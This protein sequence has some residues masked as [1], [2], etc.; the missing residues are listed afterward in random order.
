MPYITPQFVA[1]KRFL[2][3]E[4]PKW[5]TAVIFFRDAKGS[6]DLAAHLSGEPLA[7]KILWGMDPGDAIP[8]VYETMINGQPVGIVTRA[9]WG[10]PQAAILVEELAY[11]GVETIIGIGA[12]GSI[13]HE[14]GKGVQVLA[15]EGLVTDGTSRSYTPMERALPDVDLLEAAAAASHEVFGCI[16]FVKAA[17]VDAV[18]RE[19]REAVAAWQEL[20][21]DI[22]NMET[23]PFYAASTVCG[24]RSI[25]IGHVSDCLVGEA[26]EDWSDLG[27]MTTRTAEWANA[28]LHT[29]V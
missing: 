16:E 29:I 11:L 17:T 14:F 10:G 13:S 26:W 5:R 6:A 3:A 12:C 27:P 18:Y 2:D 8:F 20:G 9:N 21:A 15:T 25:W 1:E 23:S 4:K 22:I 24:V 19:T 7:R 28:L